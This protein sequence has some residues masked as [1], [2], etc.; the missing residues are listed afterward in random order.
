MNTQHRLL[1]RRTALAAT[2]SLVS[3]SA[4]WAFDPVDAVRRLAGQ[5]PCL[6]IGLVDVSTSLAGGP[7]ADARAM[8]ALKAFF[9]KSQAGDQ[10]VVGSI[11]DARMDRVRMQM[12][13]VARTGKLF[14]DK[15][16]LATATAEQLDWATAELAR[17]RTT[18]TRC[19]ETLAAHQPA[20]MRAIN[21][22]STVQLLVAGDGVE[23]SDWCN[24]DDVRLL[25]QR[26]VPRLVNDLVQRRMLLCAP[27]QAKPGQVQMMLVGAG[28]R[29]STSW[30]HTRSFWE[31]YCHIAGVDLTH[32]GPDL[33]PFL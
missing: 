29:T 22:G 1:R 13:G 27:K 20:V 28:G 24:F 26:S 6:R 25:N 31:A 5:V 18:A 7:Q 14:E 32:Y 9:A 12:R 15:K 4:A 17:P 19:V 3:T 33:P 8:R 30:Q 2:F 10:L 23:S 21:A 16:L 11:S